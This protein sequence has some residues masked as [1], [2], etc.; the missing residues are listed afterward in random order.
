MKPLLEKFLE[1]WKIDSTDAKYSDLKNSYNIT[2]QEFNQMA[3]NYARTEGKANELESASSALEAAINLYEYINWNKSKTVWFNDSKQDWIFDWMWWYVPKLWWDAYDAKNYYDTLMS[4]LTLDKLIETKKQW[5]T[6]WAMSEWEWNLLKSAATSLDW[7][8]TWAKFKENLENM[9][10]GMVRA[11]EEWWWKL[12]SNYA[13][14]TASKEYLQWQ[15]DWRYDKYK[16]EWWN[17]W[18]QNDWE[19]EML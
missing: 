8:S 6:Y 18:W 2:D 19:P 5:A 3:Q 9:I 1:E 14:S 7:G 4:N 15:K 17:K 10:Y 16:P 12:P 11:I 13:G